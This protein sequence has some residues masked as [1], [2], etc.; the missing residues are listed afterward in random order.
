[1][2]SLANAF[3]HEDL[4][5]FIERIKKFLNI[6]SLVNI[7][8]INEPKIDGLSI[9][10]FYEKGNLKNA[11]TRGDGYQ[12]ENVTNNVLTIKEIPLKLKGSNIPDLIEIRGE[13]F[14]TKNDSSKIIFLDKGKV[15]D[16]GSYDYLI[17]NN[18]IFKQ[19]SGENRTKF[20]DL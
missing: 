7:E 3:N 2:L 8:F 6:D 18:L 12:G 9:N 19:M 15:V 4:K 10:L 17:K 13:I 1:M 14:L 5:E 16:S 20:D 11:S